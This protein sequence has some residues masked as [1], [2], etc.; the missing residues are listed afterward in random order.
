MDLVADPCF[1][2]PSRSPVVPQPLV[3]PI[4]GETALGVQRSWVS[5]ITPL[6]LR[7]TPLDTAD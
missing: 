5:G 4:F 2:F 7:H 1:L 6:P 3:N